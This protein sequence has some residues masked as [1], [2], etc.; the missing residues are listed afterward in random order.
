MMDTGLLEKGAEFDTLPETW[1]IFITENDVLGQGKPLYHIERCI[2]ETGEEFGDGAH[3][4]YVNGAYRDGTPLGKLMRDFACTDPDEMHYGL[5][6][7]RVRFFKESREGV[8]IMCRA[9]EEL[10]YNSLQEGRKE[11]LQEGQRKTAQRMLRD[12]VLPVDKIAEYSGL[13]VWEV[14]KLS[15]AGRE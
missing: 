7:G 14:E 10:R 6:A 15:E 8:V 2:R 4:L 3:I 13:E 1:V 5:L 11:G 12:G 9:M